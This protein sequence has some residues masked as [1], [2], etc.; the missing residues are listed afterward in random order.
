MTKALEFSIFGSLSKKQ[1]VM[2]LKHYPFRIFQVILLTILVVLSSGCS[3]DSEDDDNQQ[4]SPDEIVIPETTK[5]ISKQ[6][7]EDNLAGIDSSNYTLYFKKGITDE[8]PL[9]KGDVIISTEG[10]G[11]L[12]RVKSIS[13]EGDKIKIETEQA[14]LTDAI[15][16]GSFSA[17]IKLTS[18]KISSIKN[19]REGVS[20]KDYGQKSDSPID[21]TISTYLDPEHKVK[22]YGEFKIT[23]EI[24][25]DYSIKWH[26]FTPY[27]KNISF[28]VTVTQTLELAAQMDLIDA[29]FEKEVE[30][31][32][33]KFTPITVMVG[34][35]PVILTPEVSLSAGLNAGIY[36]GV[37]TGVN[38]EMSYT[39]GIEYN[40]D[41][42]SSSKSFDKTLTFTS[43]Q[44]NCNANAKVY[45]KPE[46]KVMVYSVVGPYIFGDLYGRLEADIQANPWWSVYVGTDLG[47]GVS[48]EVLGE[49]IL[50]YSTDP[51]LIVFEKLV[52]SAPE[53]TTPVADFEVDITSGNA[54]LTVHFTDLSENSPTSWAW[55]FGDG[56]TSTEQ[57]PQHTFQQTGVYTVSLTASNSAGSDTETKENLINVTSGG[58]GG[59]GYYDGFAITT[60]KYLE[61]A[62]LDQAVKNE[63]GNNYRIA[64]WNDLKTYAL[65]H[66]I[67]N[68]AD[69]IGMTGD[70]ITLWVTRNGQGFWDGDTQRHYI[71]ERHDHNPPLY[72]LIHDDIDNNFIDLGSWFGIQIRILAV[73][74]N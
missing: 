65:T 34:T 20:I 4:P 13:T 15:Q 24:D 33:I 57:N 56:T 43:P 44:L 63:L 49:E 3:K 22:V 14:K 23:P 50:D 10:G 64:D 37:Y 60:N 53:V 51:P 59:G 31:G 74:T 54:P 5:V 40:N 16:Q 55:D 72:F 47:L 8:T 39:M 58:G 11:L 18:D 32:T 67:E 62:D 46:V 30:L 68:W 70:N 12:R 25:F 66:D 71:I 48:A 26:Y 7:W 38:E 17:K 1:A 36:C 45:I 42:W 21:Y 61:T 6:T 73:K 41:N 52:A 35:V 27:V 69:Q 28:D 2:K 9:E 29:S 19:L